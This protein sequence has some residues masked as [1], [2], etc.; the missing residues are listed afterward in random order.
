MFWIAGSIL[1]RRIQASG[2]A[3]R[4]SR[5]SGRAWR[6][7]CWLFR[8]EDRS[9]QKDLVEWLLSL[10][11]SR[12][13]A[14]AVPIPQPMSLPHYHALR[15]RNSLD[16]PMFG[17]PMQPGLSS[18]TGQIYSWHTSAPLVISSS[19]HIS[20]PSHTWTFPPCRSPHLCNGNKY[21]PFH[22][23]RKGEYGRGHAKLGDVCDGTVQCLIYAFCFTTGCGVGLLLGSRLF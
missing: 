7:N 20:T 8:E 14:P 15:T 10:M 3:K 5:A 21:V 9:Q 17:W 2:E 4:K 16:S 18:W 19:L 22:K 11:A 12:M 13:G 1:K 6:Q 23:Q